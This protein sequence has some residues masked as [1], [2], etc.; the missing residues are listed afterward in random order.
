MR[1]HH[2]KTTDLCFFFDTYTTFKGYEKLIL[3]KGFRKL[4]N[5]CPI[6]YRTILNE[7]AL[8]EIKLYRG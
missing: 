7:N 2:L 1:I 6:W 4:K 5:F 8:I 3:F